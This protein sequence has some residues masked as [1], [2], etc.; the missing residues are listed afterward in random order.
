MRRNGIGTLWYDSRKTSALASFDNG[1]VYSGDGLFKEEMGRYDT[2]GV[3]DR[4]GNQVAK[5]S[6]NTAYSPYHFSTEALCTSDSSSIYKGGSTWNSTLAAYDGDSNGACAAA[7]LY[8]SLYSS[9][10]MDDNITSTPLPPAN[11]TISTYGGYTGKRETASGISAVVIFIVGIVATIAFYFTSWGHNM[12]FGEESGLQAFFMSMACAVISFFIIYHSKSKDFAD[13]TVSVAGCYIFVY[14]GILVLSL[15]GC[16]KQNR[17]S[18][19]NVMLIL[20]GSVLGT[21]GVASP[22]CLIETIAIYVAKQL[23]NDR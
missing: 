1:I 18:F 20:F 6:G 15:I 16:A 2:Y 17:I 10:K 14:I 8:F 4:F 13:I 5:F 9:E 11:D 22:F 3:Y 12:V 21:V 23:K 19:G 7:V